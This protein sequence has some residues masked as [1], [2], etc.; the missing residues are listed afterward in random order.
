MKIDKRFYGE[1]NSFKLSDLSKII[2]STFPDLFHSCNFLKDQTI[3]S[4]SSIESA[5][6]KDI[7]FLEN[8]K[9]FKYLNN[10]NA[11]CLIIAP[12]ALSLMTNK[13]FYIATKQPRRVFAHIL[14]LISPGNLNNQNQS[15][16]SDSAILKKGVV[17]GENVLIENNVVIGENSV[18]GNGVIISEGTEIGSNCTILY[19]IIGKNCV[20][21]PGARIGTTGFGFNFDKSGVYKFPHRGRVLIKNNVEIGANST[22]D[23]GSLGDTIINDFV[24]IDNLVHIAHN[25][26]IGKGSIICGQSG[27]AGSSNIGQNVVIAAQV[28]IS[29]H[30]NIKS[31]TILTARSGVTKDVTDAKIMGGFPAIPIKEFRKQQASIRMITKKFKKS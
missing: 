9:Y 18:I 8:K 31:N 4:C 3:N 10:N 23:R 22:I 21:Y 12:E 1:S 28:G 7:V 15:E 24:M 27:I 14:N 19:S 30:L 6:N 11:V 25:V 29:G 13:N 16:V 2:K 26:K 17:I 5:S 20:I